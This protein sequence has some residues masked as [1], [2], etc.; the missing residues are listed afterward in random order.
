MHVYIELSNSDSV[1]LTHDDIATLICSNADSYLLENCAEIGFFQ[2]GSINN[3][4][5]TDGYVLQF[6]MRDDVITGKVNE[7]MVRRWLMP[8]PEASQESLQRDTQKCIQCYG[9]NVLKTTIHD[10]I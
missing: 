7:N 6:K 3:Y 10:L 4:K 8:T 2:V 9:S 1:P 5:D